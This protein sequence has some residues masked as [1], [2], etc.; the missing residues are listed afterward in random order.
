MADKK[1]SALTA[2][3]TPLAGTEVLP[4]VQGG[5]TVKVSVADLTAG[6]SVS[7]SSVA[8]GLGTAAL[9]SYTFTG[10]TNTG[11][12]SPGADLIA[13]SQGGTERLRIVGSGLE[14]SSI[15]ATG[16]ITS[17]GTGA[18]GSNL[19]LIAAAASPNIQF[20]RTGYENWYMG[21]PNNSTDLYIS[22][23]SAAT[24]RMY[25]A[26]GGNV[27]VSAGN[28]VIG[29]TAKGITTGSSIPLG[30]GVNNTV[31]AM[32]ID[33]ASNLGVGTASPATRVH[34]QSSASNTTVR[35]TSEL[36]GSF[37][38][39]GFEVNRSGT[40]GG[41]LMRASRD[42]AQGGAGWEWLVTADNAAEVS[43]TYTNG[44]TLD[45]L[46]N[47]KVANSISVGT[48]GTIFSEPYSVPGNIQTWFVNNGSI[49]DTYI[50]SDTAQRFRVLSGVGYQWQ[51]A[52][53]GTAGNAISYTTAMTLDLSGNLGIGTTTP[54][55]TAILDVQSTTKGVRFP[56]MTSTEKNA[57]TPS[58]GTVV[59]DTTLSKLCVYSGAAWQTITSI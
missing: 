49:N 20:L 7:S 45:T 44:M 16:N 36:S 27:T 13:F 2:S 9:P 41:A 23:G 57:I 28:L 38:Y 6:R 58:A 30:F 59:F 33:T 54:A 4:I 53:S 10:D 48:T 56:N 17:T 19:R 3:A 34:A 12:W 26:S 11:M 40:A 35:A 52:G 18:V 22:A 37:Y 39:S 55:A 46:G 15:A 47:L 8:N 42:A 32:T 31:T 50:S 1:I 14:T 21:S 43:G 25:F 24:Y 51:L 29:T 5:S